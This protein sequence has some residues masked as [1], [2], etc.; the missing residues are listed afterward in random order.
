MDQLATADGENGRGTDRYSEWTREI[1]VDHNSLSLFWKVSF[2][3][4]CIVRLSKMTKLEV[5]G[6]E[7]A[8]SWMHSGLVTVAVRKLLLDGLLLVGR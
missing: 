6:A 8:P 5:I 7:C 1:F 4:P 2:E 3:I